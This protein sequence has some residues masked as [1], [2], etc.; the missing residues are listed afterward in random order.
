[1]SLPVDT[2]T[3]ERKEEKW[4]K[5]KIGVGSIVTA[6]VGDMEKKTMEGKSR[7]MRRDLVGCFQESQWLSKM[8]VRMVLLCLKTEMHITYFAT[9][10]QLHF[11]AVVILS[12]CNQILLNISPCKN[13]ISSHYQGGVGALSL[14]ECNKHY[15]RL[16]SADHFLTKKGDKGSP[17]QMG[18]ARD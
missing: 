7:R 2:I 9:S 14:L 6:K 13:R 4:G 11:F 15:S 18:A 1:M 10:L 12:Y 3:K 5:M 17:L 16:Y 8:Q